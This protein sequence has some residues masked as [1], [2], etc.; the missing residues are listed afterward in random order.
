MHPPPPPPTPARPVLSVV[1]L[2]QLHTPEIQNTRNR[3]VGGERWQN[4]LVPVAVPHLLGASASELAAL[5]AEF[6][7][8]AAGRPGW[9]FTNGNSLPG[10]LTI[11]AYDAYMQDPESPR[12]PSSSTCAYRAG[13]TIDCATFTYSNPTKGMVGAGVPAQLNPVTPHV[14]RWIQFICTNSPRGGAGQCPPEASTYVDPHP[15]DDTLPFFY[16]EAEHRIFSSAKDAPPLV[17]NDKPGRSFPASRATVDWRAHLYLAE[18]NGIAPNPGLPGGPNGEVTIH[19]GIE[20]GFQLSC[21]AIHQ[22]PSTYHRGGVDSD[23]VTTEQS[24]ID[25]LAPVPVGCQSSDI[26]RYRRPSPRR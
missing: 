17:F 19:D 7:P 25:P 22:R 26:S 12:D 6:P 15:N 20:W 11:D 10:Y 13:E 16:T 8:P 24:G 21:V 1:T 2:D 5:T 23:K 18:W 4:R 3:G 9:V 14:L